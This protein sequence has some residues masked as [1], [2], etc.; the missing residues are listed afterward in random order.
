MVN[1][2]IGEACAEAAVERHHIY[3]IT[4]AANTTMMHL[5][6]GVDPSGIGKSPYVSAFTR[7]LTIPA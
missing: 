4:I 1:S 6:L 3:E 7:G 2:L 5:L